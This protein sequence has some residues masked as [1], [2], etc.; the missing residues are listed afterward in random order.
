MKLWRPVPTT[1]S[2]IKIFSAVA[3]FYLG[4]GIYLFLIGGKLIEENIRYDETCSAVTDV[5]PR[6]GPN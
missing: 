1:V 2:A 3:V 4:I 5:F 6:G